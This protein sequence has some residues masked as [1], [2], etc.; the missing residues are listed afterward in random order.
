MARRRASAD[1]VGLG[2]ARESEAD[3]EKGKEGRS[4]GEELVGGLLIH[5]VAT[6]WPGRRARGGGGRPRGRYRRRGRRPRRFCAEP[7]G[8]FVFISFGSF[9][10][11]IFCF[12]NK[13]CSILFI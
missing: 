12:I 2:F 1:A 4:R 6:A 3:R 9:P 8:S 7:P 10:F 5:G 13:T 11:L